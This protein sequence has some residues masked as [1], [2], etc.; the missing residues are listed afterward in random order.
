MVGGKQGVECRISRKSRLGAPRFQTYSEV[1]Y[2]I[3]VYLM[4]IHLIGVYSMGVHL[5]GVY[6]HEVHKMVLW[7]WENAKYIPMS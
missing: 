1:L 4:G 3:G 2:L 7:F 5:I 6:A